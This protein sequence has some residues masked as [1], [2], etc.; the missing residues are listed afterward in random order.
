[1]T[2]TDDTETLDMARQ[3]EQAELLRKARDH[4][5]Q[6]V[7][8]LSGA[9]DRPGLKALGIPP[10]RI[11]ELCNGAEFTSADLAAMLGV[12]LPTLRNWLAPADNK[13]HREMPM[14]AKLLLARILADSRKK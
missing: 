5:A 13:V 14:T 4:L 1:M 7:A 8:A 12:S 2:D 9:N 11:Q 3:T 6:R 10:D